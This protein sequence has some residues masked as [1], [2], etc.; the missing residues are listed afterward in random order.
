MLGKIAAGFVILVALVVAKDMYVDTSADIAKQAQEA[1][2]RPADL[3]KLKRPEVRE[4]C[5]KHP[6]WLMVSCQEAD[7]KS[8]NIGMAPEEV[9]LAWGKPSSINVTTTSGVESEQWVYGS[10]FYVYLYNGIVRSIQTSR[11]AP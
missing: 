4:A 9:R 11:R 6:E 10:G 5:A 7:E 1:S 3:A 2:Q 8:V